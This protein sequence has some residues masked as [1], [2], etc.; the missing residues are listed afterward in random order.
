MRFAPIFLPAESSSAKLARLSNAHGGQRSRGARLRQNG[1]PRG[2]KRSWDDDNAEMALVPADAC[3]NAENEEG[4]C[5]PKQRVMGS[6]TVESPVPT[7]SPRCSV[8][9]NIASTNVKTK[10]RGGEKNKWRG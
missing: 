7:P 8:I 3:G 4:T 5:L 2:A 6:S 1:K 10:Q 9:P